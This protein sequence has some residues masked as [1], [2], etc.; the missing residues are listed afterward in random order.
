MEWGRVM[1]EGGE[2]GEPLVLLVTGEGGDL[3]DPQI[4]E[5]EDMAKEV[6]A[7]D[8]ELG[9][10]TNLPIITVNVNMIIIGECII[11]NAAVR[12]KLKLWLVILIK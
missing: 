11:R 7:L 8:S 1:V 3:V 9:E 12:A 2:E 4:M 10:H 5:E 6:L